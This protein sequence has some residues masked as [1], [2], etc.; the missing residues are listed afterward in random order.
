MSEGQGVDDSSIPTAASR[1]G[2]SALDCLNTKY[3]RHG[4]TDFEFNGLVLPPELLASMFFSLQRLMIIR[5]RC[6]S[7]RTRTG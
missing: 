3:D 2:K 5:Y 1:W 7:Q 6:Y 4:V